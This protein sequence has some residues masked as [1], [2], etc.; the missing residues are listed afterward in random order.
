MAERV[1]LAGGRLAQR[2]SLRAPSMG[3]LGRLRPLFLNLYRKMLRPKADNEDSR[4]RELIL[5]IMLAGLALVSMAAL[6]ATLVYRFVIGNVAAHNSSLPITIGF[7]VVVLALWI[8]SRR[9]WYQVGVYTLLALIWLGGIN[10][11]LGWSIELPQAE[12][13]LALGVGVAGVLISGRVGLAA[14]FMTS[15]VVI[16]LGSLQASSTLDPS[17]DWLVQPVR[18]GDAVGYAAIFTIMGLVSWLANREIDKSLRRA[19]MSES[20]LKHE[21]DTLEFR[22]VE[23]TQEIERIQLQRMLEMQRFAEFGR[24]SAG[25]L[26]DVSNPLTAASLNLQQLGEESHSRVFQDVLRSL[27]YLERYIEAARKQLQNESELKSFPVGDELQQVVAILA[28]KARRAHVP[29]A[30]KCSRRQRLF[31]DPV[32]FSQ[33]AANLIANAIEAYTDLGAK[34]SN[35][36]VLVTVLRKDL[37]VV[38]SVRD[39]GVGITDSAAA[40]IFSP[41][42][43]TKQA[44]GR[45]TGIGLSMVKQ[46]VEKDFNGSITVVSNPNDGTQF[47]ARL[48]NGTKPAAR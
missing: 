37:V 27:G 30:L 25:F 15:A 33:L 21:R 1:E 8:L 29:I 36:G 42:Y 43:S 48:H 3:I 38:L 31:G 47:V 4:R 19:R 45:G 17:T 41:F 26:H 32:K 16:L 11:A 44:S 20:A 5:N 10:L 2:A 9:G 39:Y 22:V 7:V 40:E 35:R 34:R 13:T 23:R 14:A 12:L 6:T 18:T 24:F 46:I 28:L